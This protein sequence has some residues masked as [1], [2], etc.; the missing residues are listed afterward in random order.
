MKS[1]KLTIKNI[2]GGWNSDFKK[3]ST[4][5]APQT[6]PN[7]YYSGL[8]NSSLPNYLGQIANGIS[9]N[10]ETVGTVSLPI[11][12]TKASDGYG[13]FIESNGLITKGGVIGSFPT[14]FSPSSYTEPTGC[15]DDKWKDIWTHVT[16]SGVE[17]T[18]FTYQTAGNAFVGYRE[19]VSGTRNNTY[20]TLSTTNVPHVG[21]V[22]VANQSYITDGRYV[23]AYNPN[24]ASPFSEYIDVGS[25]WTT[26]SIADYGNYVAI[27]GNNG[28]TSRMWLWNGTSQD[29]SF[30]YDIRDTTVT[31]IINE[32]GTLR[33]FTYGKNSTTKIKTFNGS[34]FS[35]EADWEIPTTLCASP[36]H[37]MVDVWANQIV[38]ITP[39]G[40]LWT[41]GSPKKNEIQS[42]AHR[43]GK[44]TTTSTS[45]GCVKNLD[46]DKLF[47]GIKSTPSQANIYQ[48]ANNSTYQLASSNI[49]TALYDLPH[50]ASITM[51][52]LYF[53][54]FRT[55]TNSTS[56]FCNVSL[57]H[58]S[59]PVDLLNYSVPNNLEN[60]DYVQY[61]PIKRS[62]QGLDTFYLDID[63]LCIIKKIEIEFTYEDNSI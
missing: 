43:I 25:G 27:V 23:R 57:Y 55:F 38:W 28:N 30:Q 50:G 47:I 4:I 12:A 10:P 16:P 45:L 15:L 41:Y 46:S 54:K 34:S 62:I 17:A 26:V 7:T 52:R 1:G 13:Y 9:E 18:F 59:N 49:K 56:D 33:V 44:M 42:G 31:A 40:F 51:I 60:N 37:N 5:S 11:N 58:G 36:A 29:P 53:S 19:I 3:S 48:V 21:V 63:F 32:G 2:S 6:S 24:G 39:D 14:T 22:S 8:F 20:F 61:H 35:E